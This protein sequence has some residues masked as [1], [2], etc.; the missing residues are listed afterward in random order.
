MPSDNQD[1][2]SKWQALEQMREL[3]Q[4][5]TERERYLKDANIDKAEYLKRRERAQKV[6][7][8]KILEETKNKNGGDM[9]T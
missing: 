4:Q 5:K 9:W 8:A 6:G 2:Y 3:D 1:N 7:F